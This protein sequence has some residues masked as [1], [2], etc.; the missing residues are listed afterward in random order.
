MEKKGTIMTSQ[1]CNPLSCLKFF[2]RKKNILRLK[3]LAS[4]SVWRLRPDWTEVR[5]DMTPLAA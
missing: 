3:N 2:L 1:M 5:F 4:L